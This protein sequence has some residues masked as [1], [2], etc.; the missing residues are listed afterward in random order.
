VLLGPV[1]SHFL[2]EGWSLATRPSH[3]VDA[4]TADLESQQVQ[5]ER[6]EA[7]EEEEVRQEEQMMSEALEDASLKHNPTLLAA[8]KIRRDNA[9]AA[10]QRR[11]REEERDQARAALRD[12]RASLKMKTD[13]WPAESLGIVPMGA[14]AKDMTLASLKATQASLN[15]VGAALGRTPSHDVA[16]NSS[17]VK[18]KENPPPKGARKPKVEEPP[19]PPPPEPTPA[20]RGARRSVEPPPPPPP[21]P[22]RAASAKKA[23]LS[24]A[25]PAPVASTL[26][27]AQALMHGPESAARMAFV[28]NL[29]NIAET[30]GDMRSDRGVLAAEVDRHCFDDVVLGLQARPD[31]RAPRH[32]RQDEAAPCP[33]RHR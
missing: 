5:R 31:A 27:R 9:R 21:P 24:R 16:F 10:V 17:V 20:R 2:L 33:P 12:T 14:S 22:K 32:G 4:L 8:A 29:L 11:Q 26:A 23:P 25:R 6:R 19:P 18:R 1:D 15:K 7:L 13:T 30:C 3:E 28:D